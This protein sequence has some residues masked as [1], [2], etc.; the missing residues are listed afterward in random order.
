MQPTLE[1]DRPSNPP[2]A[3]WIPDSGD[4]SIYRGSPIEMVHQ[5]I[6]EMTDEATD[7]GSPSVFEAV[8]ILL[9]SL[10]DN[11]DIF[12]DVNLDG[13]TDETVMASTL[14]QILLGTGIAKPMPKA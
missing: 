12:I 14:I 9:E 7:E 11:R 2:S 8:D 3:I 4:V 13:V 6:E 10:A 5:M 1:S